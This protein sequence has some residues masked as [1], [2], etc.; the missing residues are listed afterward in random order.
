MRRRPGHLSPRFG[1][2]L[3]R[4]WAAC[5]RRLA[6]EEHGTVIFISAAAMFMLMAMSALAVDTARWYQRHHQ[7]QVAA[8]AASLAAANCLANAGFGKTCTS[9][10]DTTD[11][12]AV[13]Q[14]I[15]SDNGVTLTTSQFSFAGGKVTI[16]DGASAGSVFAGI[17]GINTVSLSANASAGFRPGT[18]S[19]STSTYPTTIT[20][21][22]TI[23]NPVTTTTPIVTTTPTTTTQTVTTPVTGSPLVMFAMDTN[24]ADNGVYQ[25]GGS[26]VINGGVFS[27]SSIFLDVGGSSY[28]SLT[29][30]A[31]AGCKATIEGDSG[32]C[33]NCSPSA[34][35]APITSWPVPYGSSADPL[36]ACTNTYT[37][38][39]TWSIG[40]QPTSTPQVFCYP[41]G[42]ILLT[43]WGNGYMDDTFLCGSISMQGGG[44]GM[45]AEDYPANKLLVYATGTGTA[46]M[47]TNG[48]GT[49]KG[50]IFTPNGTV[51]F[52]SG[53]NSFTGL[54]EGLD[55]NFSGGGNG[56][57]DGPTTYGF[58][59]STQTV[60]T[61]QTT[62]TYTTT[63]TNQYT[64][65]TATTVS[66]GTT[67]QTS[68]TPGSD[69]L[70]Q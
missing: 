43:G 56:I 47:L 32:V 7:A 70:V 3:R 29:Y 34:A 22:G 9:G 26:T 64:T 14:T 23:T 24:C 58:V 63:V 49:M 6:R 2:R 37:G 12:I 19:T 60:T 8:D 20:T 30:G 10:T 21:T 45:S 18:V 51:G 54:L 69:G 5:C 40:N 25:Q 41:G 50:D 57:G 59:T 15:A 46:A 28:Q 38:S 67:T 68:T 52:N 11:A 55:V 13:A 65:T 53:S 27:N 66:T 1:Q 48:A 31:G 44:V 33:P 16:N 61:A 17:A 35:A 39:G 62:T 36:P 4:P 42:T